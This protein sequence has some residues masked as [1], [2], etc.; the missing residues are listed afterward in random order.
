MSTT[1][2]SSRYPDIHSSPSST[3]RR[4]VASPR[5]FPASARV[6][7]YMVAL[8]GWPEPVYI[9][10]H[11]VGA[12]RG[13]QSRPGTPRA[14]L[15]GPGGQVPDDYIG[16]DKSAA[17]VKVSVSV[18]PTG[19]VAWSEYLDSR[20]SGPGR[21]ITPTK[22]PTITE[23]L[24]PYLHS[25][26]RPPVF[27][28]PPLAPRAS[29]PVSKQAHIPPRP[30]L[31]PTT[32]AT[33]F[34]SAPPQPSSSGHP[35]HRNTAE[36]SHGAKFADPRFTPRAAVLGRQGGHLRIAPS[37]TNSAPSP[38]AARV[39]LSSFEHTPVYSSIRTQQ[40]VDDESSHD[41]IEKDVR[42]GVRHQDTRM[43]NA[44]QGVGGRMLH[45]GSMSGR[46]RPVI[47]RATPEVYPVPQQSHAGRRG[48]WVSAD[49]VVGVATEVYPRDPESTLLWPGVD[50]REG[51][52]GMDSH[53]TSRAGTPSRPTSPTS[54]NPVPSAHRR[55]YISA[56]SPLEHE[57]WSPT[58]PWGDGGERER[59]SSN[60]A[61]SA[62]EAEGESMVVD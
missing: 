61:V 35:A 47:L 16:A 12:V 7:P 43:D 26:T 42:G 28:S 41:I 10:S 22:G 49:A 3:F 17:G 18:A 53:P 52:R 50:R 29:S 33:L 6:A 62:E 15:S 20:P 32:S 54:R 48:S 59:S 4:N 31:P 21:P 34:S 11:G 57:G 14:S 13:A 38:A 8:S 1:P 37:W 44:A 30:N 56:V 40:P 27:P 36:A 2:T 60:E 9:D 19:A 45:L 24:Y 46:T 51:S 55:Q 23:A 25:N 39:L 58:V 5:K